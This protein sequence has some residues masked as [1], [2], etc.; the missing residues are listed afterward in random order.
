MTEGLINT[1]G[2]T[3]LTVGQVL[4]RVTLIQ[5][6][7]DKVMKEGTHYGASFPGD[8]KKNLLKPGAEVLGV[9]FQLY[10]EFDV[11]EQ[12]FD[13]WHRNFKIKCTVKHQGT[14]AVVAHGVGSCSTLESKY[15]YRKQARK[16][17][18]CQ[19]ESIIKG[20]E[21]Y[22]G[23][24]V[25]WKKKGGCDAKF[26]DA[27]KSITD[28]E[29]GRV[30]NQDPADLWNTC[31]KIGK[32]RAYVDAMI[33]ATGCSDMFT[34]DLEDISENYEAQK[35][36]E[37]AERPV[38]ATVVEEQKKDEKHQAK[39]GEEDQR[40]AAEQKAQPQ[41]SGTLSEMAQLVFAAA[42][43]KLDAV[44]NRNELN[45]TW[46]AFQAEVQNCDLE[47][48]EAAKVL[49]DVWEYRKTQAIRV[50]GGS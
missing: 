23:G 26:K 44:T 49:K 12:V 40:P 7:M 25:C 11:E 18:K 10:P 34:Q 27:D 2:N 42:C 29:E 9:T 46:E 5:E 41:A 31:Q 38:E 8:E 30:E 35:K 39:A 32:K 36:K 43:A 37:A 33:T 15:R 50:A 24:W 20:S 1:G 47:K 28:Q 22:G 16:C 45:K 21:K 19:K 14:G 4:G 48:S 3:Q 6:I 17:P 13:A